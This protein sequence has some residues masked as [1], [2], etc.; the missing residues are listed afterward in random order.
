MPPT[1]SRG[2]ENVIKEFHD[3][4]ISELYYIVPQ[5]IKLMTCYLECSLTEISDRQCDK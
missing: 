4:K 5:E 2:L 1:G 3:S